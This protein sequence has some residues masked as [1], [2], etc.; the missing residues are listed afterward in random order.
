MAH[1]LNDC[2]CIAKVYADGSG[3]DI[4]FCPMHAAAPEL[5]EALKEI[6]DRYALLDARLVSG[7]HSEP[8]GTIERARA[9]I[10]KAEQ[11]S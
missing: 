6:A 5:L 10:A 3:V 1:T 11:A 2:G 4:G 8:N 7:Q 9:A